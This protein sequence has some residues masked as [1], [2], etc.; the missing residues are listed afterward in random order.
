MS[1]KAGT[2]QAGAPPAKMK[3]VAEYAGVSIKTVSRVLNNEPYV[4]EKLRDKVRD[5]VQALNYVPSQSAR[6]L[7]GSRSYNITQI[8]HAGDSAYVQQVQFGAMV[9]CQQQGYQLSI[10]LIEMLTKNS[11][12]G[13]REHLE[14]MRNVYQPDGV[15]L[16]A[17]YSSSHDVLEV[18][19]EL[20]LPV[21]CIGPLPE[22]EAGAVVQ[23]DEKAAARELTEHLVGLGHT[24]IGFI[25]GVENQEATH[26]RFA[27]FSEAMA[28]AGLT[29]EPK[30]VKPGNFQFEGGFAAGE[31]L[32]AEADRPTAI[33]AANDDMAAGLITAAREAGIEVPRDL[34]VVGFDDSS[35]AT[36][37]RPMLTTVRQPINEMGARGID[38]FVHNLGR[39]GK[40]AEST[41]ILPYELILRDTTAP[42]KS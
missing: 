6:S 16:T 35:V 20:G 27:A 10:A 1:N 4:Q 33:F 7:R 41:V 25:R 40:L 11:R 28:A 23:I 38:N 30:W 9:A 29:V 24:K 18:L 32:L 2:P 3:D 13:I 26:L 42:P 17:P 31:E 37:M 22:G 34:S 15:L 36:R 8:C 12:E 5:A 39:D 21:T 14:R 19:R